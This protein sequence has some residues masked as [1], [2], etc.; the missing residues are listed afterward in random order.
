VSKRDFSKLWPWAFVCGAALLGVV[1][2]AHA[3]DMDLALSRLGRGAC[4]RTTDPNASD[5]QLSVGTGNAS[6][7]TLRPDNQAWAQLVT[8]LAP[9]VM[10]AVLAP[11]TT[12]GP[13]GFDVAFQTSVTGIDSKQDYWK[14]GSQGHGSAARDTCD[15]R[16]RFVSPLFVSNRLSVDKGLPLGLTVGA[17]A[18]RVWDTSLWTVGGHLKWALIE[19]YRTWPTP[20]LG[21]RVA[22]NTVVGDSQFAMTVLAAD[23]ILSK[24]IVAGRVMQIAPFL[25][26]GVAMVFAR[27]DVIDLTPNIDATACAAG[28]EPCTKLRPEQRTGDIGHDQAFK[29]LT[30]TRT[31]GFVGLQL[32]YR[33]FALASELA[34]DVVPPRKVDKDA[35]GG[36]LPR[37]WT[38]N[39]APSLSF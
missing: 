18:G 16:N 34:F 21:V 14:K 33:L 37:Q 3:Q 7:P 9:V 19:G 28:K 25:G 26:G 20:D 11:V 2:R 29:Q 17:E 39:I 10:P 24:N 22:A 32:R 4:E 35:G 31:R 13:R 12:S 30:M 27:S 15:G 23:A 5:F 38:F 36:G 8:Q 6:V 1:S